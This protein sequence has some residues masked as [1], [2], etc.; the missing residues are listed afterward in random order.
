M[1]TRGSASRYKFST[2]QE[3]CD[4]SC[5][6]FTRYGVYTLDTT[7]NQYYEIQDAKL[8]TIS[9][10]YGLTNPDIQ[11]IYD[12]SDKSNFILNSLPWNT[13]FIFGR[14]ISEYSIERVNS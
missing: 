1:D 11:I 13:I 6:V 12:S 2:E 14:S 8:T 3:Y 4:L 5:I 10:R 9:L 7:V